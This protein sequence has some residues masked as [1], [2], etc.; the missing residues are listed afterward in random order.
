MISAAPAAMMPFPQA[1]DTSM[2]K[3]MSPDGL[4]I[5]FR[6]HTA[7]RPGARGKSSDASGCSCGSC[8]HDKAGFSR[9]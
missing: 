8:S 5:E 3:Q 4:E 6:P 7:P 9:M 2:A 1:G